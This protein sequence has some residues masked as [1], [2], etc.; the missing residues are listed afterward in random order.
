[1]K[2]D[3]NTVVSFHYRLRDDAGQLIEDSHG[4]EQPVMVLLGHGQ[5]VAGV[6]K[7]LE[8]HEAGASFE[9]EVPPEEGYGEHRE[10]M[11]QRVP[12]KYFRDV[13]RLKPG[14]AT[15]LGLRAGGQQSVVVHKIG[16]STIDVDVNHPLAGKTLHFAIEVTGVREATPEE[17]AHGHAHPSGAHES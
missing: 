10:G 9:V 16:M 7:A 15:V 1:M 17:L 13:K 14:M 3:K 12:K 2:A 6:E 8:G 11:I 4:N 5:L